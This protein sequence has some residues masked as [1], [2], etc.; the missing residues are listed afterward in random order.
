M[1]ALPPDVWAMMIFSILAF[2]GV[3]IFALVYSLRQEEQKMQILRTEDT[4]DTHSPT[5]LRELRAWIEAHP[6]DPDADE[7][8]ATYNDCVD[9][10]WS[11]GRHFYDWSPED[12]QQLDSL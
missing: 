4:L 8:R 1:S 10:L 2:F 12:I 5:A 11:T 9:A 6:D 3:S 7:A